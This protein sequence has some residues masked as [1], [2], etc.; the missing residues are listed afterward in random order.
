M[1]E[2]PHEGDLPQLLHELGADFRLLAARFAGCGR[3]RPAQCRVPG[4]NLVPQRQVERP[5][6]PPRGRME[7]DTPSRPQGHHHQLRPVGQPCRRSGHDD[8]VARVAIGDF[9]DGFLPVGPGQPQAGQPQYAVAGRKLHVAGLR[10]VQVELPPLTVPGELASRTRRPIV[11]GQADV[12]GCGAVRNGCRAGLD[13]PGFPPVQGREQAVDGATRRQGGINGGRVGP[14][15][16]PAQPVVKASGRGEPLPLRAGQV[17]SPVALAAGLGKIEQGLDRVRQP[18]QGRFAQGQPGQ[19]RDRVGQ[20]PVE[21]EAVG[22]PSLERG[23]GLPGP[24]Q[25]EQ[26][27]VG[28]VQPLG[29]AQ[30]EGHLVG[31]AHQEER[32]GFEAQGRQDR[33]PQRQGPAQQGIGRKG[34]APRR[35][36]Q[37]PFQARPGPGARAPV[38]PALGQGTRPPQGTIELLEQQAVDHGD[39]GPGRVVQGA[40]PEQTQAAGQETEAAAGRGD[41]KDQDLLC[42][43]KLIHEKIQKVSPLV[44]RRP[45]GR[46]RNR[47][48][49]R[50]PSRDVERIKGLAQD[51]KIGGF[52]QRKGAY[53]LTCFMIHMTPGRGQAHSFFHSLMEPPWNTTVRT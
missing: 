27:A 42:S 20:K 25:P 41:A 40:Q 32:P 35:R 37:Q 28:Q 13:G 43:G 44:G 36:S 21:G 38:L 45:G 49:L 15:R 53:R 16:M 12:P 33:K 14:G 2:T 3:Q 22:S 34:G 46:L 30:G 26:V 50:A 23:Q 6:A 18:G 7:A 4:R 29:P 31:M 8:P 52:H 19:G 51:G 47:A 11:P 9:P 48:R 24:G 39:A 5:L 10:E 1:L 17:R